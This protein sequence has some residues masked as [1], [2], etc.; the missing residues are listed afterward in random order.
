MQIKIQHE[1]HNWHHI[2]FFW[3][4][5][6]RVE[7]D[8]C[9]VQCD[10]GKPNAPKHMQHE[11]IKFTNCGAYDTLCISTWYQ[12]YNIYNVG[13]SAVVSISM[14]TAQTSDCQ[15]LAPL[16]KWFLQPSVWNELHPTQR[17]TGQGFRAFLHD[18]GLNCRSVW[19]DI[20]RGNQ[21]WINP[22][23]SQV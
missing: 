5:V 7:I 1:W 4:R 8:I 3:G 12:L 14:R 18:P 15:P 20:Q 2:T 19:Q 11:N 9:L 23:F 13:Q 17:L 22:M 6:K 16:F 21:R 10:L